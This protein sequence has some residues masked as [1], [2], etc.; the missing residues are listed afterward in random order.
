MKQYYYLISSLFDLILDDSKKLIDINSYIDF[1]AEELTKTDFDAFKK[2]FLF[3]DIR[4]V[5]NYDKEESQYITPA[6]Y[7]K[8]EFSEMQKD[9][10]Q[11]LP[12]MA[13]FLYYKKNEKRLYP[14]L[15]EIDE[16][17]LLLYEDLENFNNS[18][19]TD[20]FLFELDLQNITTALSLKKNHQEFSNKIIP[21][22]DYYEKILKSNSNDFGLS[23]D[24][25]YIEKLV[26]IYESNDLLNIEKTIENIRWDWLDQKTEH[27]IFSADN[28]FAY[29]VKLNSVERWYNMTEEKG[30]EILDELISK[31]KANIKFSEEFLTIG[32]KKE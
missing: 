25:Q 20:Y 2:L 23:G 11:F 1:C 27:S 3:N 22:G 6:Y 9:T 31:I 16:L 18:F 17:V 7:T 12:F 13:K 26:D 28:V 32:G 15:Q 21:Y 8:E 4:N 24:I 29:G 19:I 5:I 30:K 10:D 14:E